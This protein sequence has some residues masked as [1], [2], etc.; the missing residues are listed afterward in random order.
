VTSIRKKRSRVRAQSQLEDSAIKLLTGI[1]NLRAD[2]AGFSWLKAN[3]PYVLEDVDV[4]FVRHLAM[5]AEEEKY[6]PSCPDEDLILRYW[7]VPLRQTLRA[8]WRVQDKMTRTWGMFRISQ[9]WFLQG[10]RDLIR[11]PRANDSDLLG[12]LR[13]PSKTERLLSELVDLFEMARFC[14]NPQCVAPYF[15]ATQ[16]NQKFCGDGCARFGKRESQRRYWAEKGSS[17]RASQRSKK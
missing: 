5:N 12:V 8:L 1:A 2:K 15:I 16:P 17:R 13:A 3:F 10:R 6:N 9:D 7:L 14:P 11:F 4:W